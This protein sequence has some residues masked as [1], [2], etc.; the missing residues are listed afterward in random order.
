[1]RKPPSD[2]EKARSRSRDDLAPPSSATASPWRG[3]RPG[4]TMT[5]AERA[6][7]QAKFLEC[8]ARWGVMAEGCR[9]AKVDRST[10]YAWLE[11]DE[12]FSLAYHQAE[13]T[14]IDLLEK[15]AIRRASKGWLRPV[16]QG[17]CLVGH[18]REFSDNLLAL[19]L[20]G[21]RPERYGDRSKVEHSGPEGAAI[22]ISLIDKVLRDA[23]AN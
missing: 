4:Q 13:A 11:V 23:D 1:M 15:E 21:R 12:D 17:G 6:A 8:F 9:Q 7:A 14:A 20:K 5:P 19:V 2:H 3:R 18:V 16:Y 10:V 22:P